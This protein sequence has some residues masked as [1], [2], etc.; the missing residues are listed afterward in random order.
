MAG[1]DR[2]LQRTVHQLWRDR[3]VSIGETSRAAAGARWACCGS[4]GQP[5]LRTPH[6]GAMNYADSIPKIPAAAIAN[7]DADRLQRL[8]GP[9]V[10][11]VVRLS[12]DPHAARCRVGQC[13]RRRLSDASIPKEVVVL[14]GHFDSRD[15]GTGAHDDGDGSVASWEAV[16][17][18]KKLGL[19][20]RH[21][22]GRPVHQRRTGFAAGKAIAINIKASWPTTC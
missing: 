13:D 14:G 5:G 20:P 21:R 11:L 12:M 7:E 15:V 19:R 4:V 2:G 18:M 17:L 10:R 22:E 9:R 6:T 16:R 3:A 8:P 1:K